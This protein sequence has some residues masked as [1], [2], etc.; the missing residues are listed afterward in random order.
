MVES[1]ISASENNKFSVS[2]LAF[3][4]K[5]SMAV[6]A[7]FLH[8]DMPNTIVFGLIPAGKRR[9]NTPM[10]S[11]SQVETNSSFKLGAMFFGAL[12][13]FAGF[14]AIQTS[15]TTGILLCAIG[16]LMFLSGI[17][18]QMSFER[19]GVR[20][21]IDVPFFDSNKITDFADQVLQTLNDY[22]MDRNMR[23][24]TQNQTQNLN[25]QSAANTQAIISAM[26]QNQVQNQAMN[27]VMP[28]QV[29]PSQ[30]P[31]QNMAPIDTTS[32]TQEQ[33]VANKF[34]PQCGSQNPENAAFCINCGNQLN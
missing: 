3:W 26:Q 34:C 1:T 12:I 28:D 24:Q 7:N 6:D 10:Q 22:Q 17:K 9:L 31:A 14:S 27:Q 4:V 21:T 25:A 5:G 15:A 16:V 33:A 13:A 29:M 32:N 18:T 20:E 19:N 23:V 11:V 8:I 30:A 2:L